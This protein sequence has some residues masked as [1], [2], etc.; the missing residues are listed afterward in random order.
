[1]NTSEA[2]IEG[3]GFWGTGLP[4]WDAARA[5]VGTGVLPETCPRKPQPTLL[6]AN[7]RRRAPDS[8]ALAIEV[9]QSACA[10]AAR[11]AATLPSVFASTHGDLAI[12]DYMCATLGEAP[13]TISPTKFHN[14]VHNAAAGY[15][16][17]GTG[18]MAPATAI[19]AYHGS[20]AQGL[21]E[22]MALLASGEPAV[23]LVAYDAE[24]HGPLAAISRSEGLLAGA[25]VLSREARAG[26]RRIA[27]RLQPG[28]AGDTDGTLV[29]RYAKN[30]MQPMLPL[31]EM[32]A[33]PAS[34]QCQL[35][36]GPGLSMH[37]DVHR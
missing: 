18:C 19:S 11:E 32:L 3:I 7:E 28:P 1:M 2:F 29:R 14:S 24:A 13:L 16:T 15:W 37:I 8:V 12:T 17:I 20:F 4:S 34:G 23:L 33:L 35:H 26:A 25:I 21:L 27:A 5:F 30:A 36:A 22:A 31:F 10:A 9:A 6:P